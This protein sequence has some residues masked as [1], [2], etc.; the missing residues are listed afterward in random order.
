MLEAVFGQNSRAAILS[1]MRKAD[2]RRRVTIDR[3]MLRQIA[4]LDFRL[5]LLKALHEFFE[6]EFRKSFSS[7]LVQR[8][9]I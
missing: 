7:R 5:W 6:I 2:V 3:L 9:I 4:S 8:I 1:R